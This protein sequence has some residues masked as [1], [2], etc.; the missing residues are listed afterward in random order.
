VIIAPTPAA[1]QF[2]GANL[3]GVESSKAPASTPVAMTAQGQGR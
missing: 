2:L 3:V 1:G